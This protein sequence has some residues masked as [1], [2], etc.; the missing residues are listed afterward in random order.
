MQIIEGGF[1]QGGGIFSGDVLVIDRLKDSAD[2][3]VVA[4]VVSGEVVVK[5]LFIKAK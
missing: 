1:I 3:L 2:G 4:T 5:R